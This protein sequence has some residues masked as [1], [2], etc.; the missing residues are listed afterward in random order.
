M[1]KKLIFNWKKS[2]WQ[3]KYFSTEKK[4]I[5]LRRKKFLVRVRDIVRRYRGSRLTHEEKMKKKRLK[6]SSVLMYTGTRM[7]IFFFFLFLLL[8]LRNISPCLRFFFSRWSE[9][10]RGGW[11]RARKRKRGSVRI[12]KGRMLRLDKI[13][14]MRMVFEQ[15]ALRNY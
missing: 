14:Y 15:Y 10:M 9:T 8:F 3:M 13:E 12:I 6:N 1:K 4:I 11:K 7:I 5:F 2:F